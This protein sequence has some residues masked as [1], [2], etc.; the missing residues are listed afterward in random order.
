MPSPEN[1]RTTRRRQPPTPQSRLDTPIGLRRA[2][3]IES[4]FFDSWTG[5]VRVGYTP[6]YI[7]ILQSGVI[8]GAD[9]GFVAAYLIDDAIAMRMWVERTAA[10]LPGETEDASAD[11]PSR[12]RTRK[13]SR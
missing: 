1:R 8:P 6:S 11:S 7:R 3:I 10:G 9:P 2:G 5:V 13:R 12:P 4:I